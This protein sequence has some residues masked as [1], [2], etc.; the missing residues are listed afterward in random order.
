MSDTH[1]HAKRYAP[2]AAHRWTVCHASARFNEG[3]PNESGPYA[4]DGQEA[5]ALLAFALNSKFRSAI[6]AKISYPATWVHRED[7]EASRLESVQTALDYVWMLLD[8]NPDAVM[9]VE[10]R[11]DFL[12]PHTNDCWGHADVIVWMPTLGI[13]EVVDLK[14]GVGEVIEAKDNRQLGIYGASTLQ[15]A[16]TKLGLSPHSVVM[17]IIQPRA[18]HKDGHV[19]HWPVSDAYMENIFIPDI[20]NHIAICESPSAAFRPGRKQCKWCPGSFD[21]KAREAAAL[22]AVPTVSSF[23]GVTSHSLPPVASIPIERLV[24]IVQ[25]GKLLK[26]YIKEAETALRNAAI[27]GHRIPGK[28][29]VEDYAKRKWYGNQLDCARE[30]MKLLETDDWDTVYPR[31]LLGITEAEDKLTAAFKARAPKSKKKEAAELAKKAMAFLTLKTQT[32]A[33]SLVDEDDPRQPVDAAR[34]QFTGVTVIDPPKGI[35]Q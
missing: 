3:K 5:H 8:G 21:C 10:V 22:A 4:L 1:E 35:G 6:E 23:Q 28:K 14:H 29:L 17:T 32:G 2:S 34:N 30:L 20:N 33:L 15:Y 12:S 7:D 26:D 31:Q 24:Y 18:F 27:Q 13:I 19:R 11:V 25:A 16:K 9:Y